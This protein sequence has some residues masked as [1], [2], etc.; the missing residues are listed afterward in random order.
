MRTSSSALFG[1]PSSRYAQ[2]A[3]AGKPT[4]ARRYLR[5]SIDLVHKTRNRFRWLGR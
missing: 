4:S 5:P 3:D 1:Y 2:R